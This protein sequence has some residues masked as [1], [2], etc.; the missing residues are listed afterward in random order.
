VTFFRYAIAVAAA[1]F[2]SMLVA[3]LIARIG[4]RLRLTDL[5]NERSSHS[6]PTPRGGG[7]GIVVG[8]FVVLIV[9]APVLHSA[10]NGLLLLCAA[11][12]VSLIGLVD[13]V[14]PV[15]ALYRFTAHLVA[16]ALVVVAMPTEWTIPL[17]GHAELTG[18]FGGLIVVLV[19]TWMIN[20]FNFMDGID[21]I[22]GGEAVFVSGVGA[23]LVEVAQP[24]HPIVLVFSLVATASAGFLVTNWPPARVFMGD[25]GSGFLGFSIAAL[26]FWAAAAHIVSIWTWLI[27]TA[28]FSVDSTVT[29][30]RRALRGEHWY[31]AHRMHAYQ[32]LARRWSSHRRVTVLTIC[33]NALW[34]L[35]C[36][37]VSVMWPASAPLASVVALLPILALVWSAGAGLPD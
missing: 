19:I 25:V 36:A 31:A 5:P 28:V 33:I 4:H 22:A 3:N 7:L 17:L 24:G 29:L 13:D 6:F 15:P 10:V 26:A 8:V 21:G 1:F 18:L 20:L 16:S 37:L 30:L 12:L 32:R 23:L 11:L 14:R 34:L 2:L 9:F 27:L 35:P